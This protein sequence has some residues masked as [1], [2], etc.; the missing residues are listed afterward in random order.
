MG[1]EDSIFWGI[2]ILNLYSCLV[3]IIFRVGNWAS[4]TLYGF[5]FNS[6][7][8]RDA[9]GFLWSFFKLDFTEA[10]LED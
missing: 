8:F 4:Y 10:N 7:S 9:A 1:L 3:I 2:V 6:S 5:A